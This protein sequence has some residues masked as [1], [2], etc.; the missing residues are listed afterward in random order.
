L[1]QAPLLAAEVVRQTDEIVEFRN[2]G[3]LEIITNSA[4][5]VRGRSA[6]AILGSECCSWRTDEHSASSDEEVVAA[7]EPS[8]AMCVDGG[9]LLLGSSVYRKRGYMYR[10][11]RQLHGNND[12][13]DICWFAPSTVMNPKSPLHVVDKALAE[14]PHKGGAEYKGIWRHLNLKARWNACLGPQAFAV[15]SPRALKLFRTP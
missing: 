8:M 1:L 2:G 7:A 6:V 11:F 13:E 15:P 3:S 12:A 9:L 14:D 4:A 5:L 10:K